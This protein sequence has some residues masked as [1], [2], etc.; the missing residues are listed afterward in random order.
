MTL[1]LN[2]SNSGFTEVKAPA[3]A[4]SN[5]IT[6]PT[7]NGSANQVLRNGSTAG[8]LEFG[9]LPSSG[10]VLTRAT[11]VNSTSGTTIDFTNIPANVYRVTVM[12]DEVSTS[13]SSNLMLRIGDSGGVE[14][15]GYK[16]SAGNGTAANT[17]ASRDPGFCL[18]YNNNSAASYAH[19]GSVVL[20]NMTGNTGALQ[21]ATF[22][23]TY[24][25]GAFIGGTKT[26]SGTLDRV[27][28]YTNNG[29]DTFD[30]GKINIIYE[31]Q[32]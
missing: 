15:T 18:S 5:T 14:T 30:A 28:V 26:L 7:S 6:L 19:S 9:D 17:Y 1:R 8:T 4:G 32:S 3:T 12:L 2:G 24:G 29:T 31:V 27:Q 10:L 25:V 21:G 20:T 23:A 16:G 11:A 13:G 22:T